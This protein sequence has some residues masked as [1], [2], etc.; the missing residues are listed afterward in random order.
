MSHIGRDIFLDCMWGKGCMK[1]DINNSVD[2]L[3]HIHFPFLLIERVLLLF[4]YPPL[5]T[6]P[7]ASAKTGLMPTPMR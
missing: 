7:H 2:F 1:F 6:C 4:R 3:L 5:S